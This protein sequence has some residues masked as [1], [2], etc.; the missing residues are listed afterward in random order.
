MAFA[1]SSFFDH[2]A[3][4]AIFELIAAELELDTILTSLTQFLVTSFKA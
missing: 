2:G 3:I 4:I 1:Y